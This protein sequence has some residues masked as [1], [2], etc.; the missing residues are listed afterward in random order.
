MDGVKAE[1]TAGAGR[2]LG[3]ERKKE[4]EGEERRDVRE[5]KSSRSSREREKESREKMSDLMIKKPWTKR[6]V[7]SMVFKNKK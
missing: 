3:L 5:L 7:W 6:T 1:S 2:R 4:L